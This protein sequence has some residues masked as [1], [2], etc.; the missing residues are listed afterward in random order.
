LPKSRLP[1]QRLTARPI[2]FKRHQANAFA[3]WRLAVDGMVEPPNL[4]F[5]A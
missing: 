1:T 5:V 2:I 3:D 4:A